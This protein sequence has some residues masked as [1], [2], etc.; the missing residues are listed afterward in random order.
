MGLRHRGEWRS[1]R[2]CSSMQQQTFANGPPLTGS[3]R[4]SWRSRVSWV[5]CRGRPRATRSR[6][7][8]SP[9]PASRRAQRRRTCGRAGA[10]ARGGAAAAPLPQLKEPRRTWR[11]VAP[12]TR[13]CL[14]RRGCLSCRPSPWPRCRSAGHPCSWPLQ[15]RQ[16][17]RWSESSHGRLE[18][19]PRL[20]DYARF[21]RLSGSMMAT[22]GTWGYLPKIVARGVM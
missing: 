15:V 12:G 17:R 5:R 20:E 4:R 16:Q 21:G 14:L 3:L 11:R 19:V 7:C 22:M 9:S 6:P 1:R 18:R 10:G 8:C 2:S 13:S